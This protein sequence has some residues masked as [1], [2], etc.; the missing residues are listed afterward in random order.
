MTHQALSSS[1][2]TSSSEGFVSGL[3]LS[4]GLAGV[5]NCLWSWPLLPL[6]GRLGHISGMSRAANH[7]AVHFLPVDLDVDLFV[8]ET[9][10][11]DVVSSH[12][13]DSPRLLS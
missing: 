7:L 3:C 1:E 12:H 9:A 13:P 4:D 11:H 10:K 6:K 8:H 5:G 2:L